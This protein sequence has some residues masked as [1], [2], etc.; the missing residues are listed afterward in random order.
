M[1]PC[2]LTHKLIPS[3]V[4][5]HNDSWPLYPEDEA[6]AFA[7]TGQATQAGDRDVLHSSGS[8]SCHVER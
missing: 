2:G 6:L 1:S 4:I 8:L 3:H 5:I 7:E